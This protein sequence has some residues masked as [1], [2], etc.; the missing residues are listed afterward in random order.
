MVHT[1][2]KWNGMES[3]AE[4]QVRTS[5]A[6]LCVKW[7]RLSENQPV[8][9][10]TRQ[11]FTLKIVLNVVSTLSAERSDAR[12]LLTRNAVSRERHSEEYCAMYD[13]CGARED[14]KVLN[15]PFGS[16]SVKPDDLLSQKIQSLCPTIT[17]NVCC[18]EDQFDT[19]RSQVQQAI[20]FLVGCPACLRNFLNLFCELTCSPHQST[21]INVTTTTK[22]KGNLTV[23]AIDFYVSDAFGEGLYESCKDVKFGTL[24]SRALNVIGAGAQN[25][26]ADAWAVDDDDFGFEDFAGSWYAFIGRR[27][28]LGMPGSPYAMTFNP[29]A[30]ESSGMKPM[31]VST[32]SCGDISLG[33]SC[34]DCPQSPVCA[35]TAPPPITRGFLCSENW[36]SQG[37]AKCIDVALTILYIILVSMFLGWGLFHRKRERN[38][39]S[40]MKPLSDIKDSGEVIRKKDENLPAQMV[41]DSPQ[42]GSRVQL[43][44]VQGYM[45]KFYRRYGTWVARNPILVLSLSLAVILLLCV[46][47]IRFKVETRPEKLILATLPDAGA[48]KSPSIVTKDNI[49]L[50]FEIQKKVFILS[51]V[52][53]WTSG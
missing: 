29:T 47:L 36:V 14:G 26:T 42:T 49:K 23:S 38:Q 9:G 21:F 52:T 3:A 40:R 24:N 10:F 7:N 46:G 11:P 22:V 2:R 31:N 39:T 16:P 20:P 41:E 25:F 5:T 30:P 8:L 18:S 48:Q 13:I 33:C 50:L 27:A 32:Y 34:G 17:G 35:N 44:I 43:S 12:L 51:G 4:R 37:E 53:S 45:S 15:C 6:L 1:G 28:P 19:L